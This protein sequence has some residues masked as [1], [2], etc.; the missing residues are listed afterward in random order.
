MLIRRKSLG[1]HVAFVT[2]RFTRE[3]LKYLANPITQE[4]MEHT[5]IRNIIK[6]KISPL[7]K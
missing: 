6:R 1:D 2:G 7:Y 3:D 4:Y 5:R